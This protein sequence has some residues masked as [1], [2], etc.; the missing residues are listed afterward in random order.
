MRYA[1]SARGF[2]ACYDLLKP[3]WFDFERQVSPCTP[4]T[5]V[6]RSR[7]CYVSCRTRTS[8]VGPTGCRG[9]ER[10]TFGCWT[11]PIP[12]DGGVPAPTCGPI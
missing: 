10:Q 1:T 11:G 9:R 4:P 7:A 8:A 5:I 2:N 12:H 3:V 6:S